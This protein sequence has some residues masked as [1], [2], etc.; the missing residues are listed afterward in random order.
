M[1]KEVSAAYIALLLGFLCRS[2]AADHARDVLECMQHVSFA[3]V[4][5]LLRSFLELHSAAQLLSDESASSMGEVV[6]WME[7]YVP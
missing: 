6:Q 1:E 4:G 3:R 5:L 7:Q 2:G